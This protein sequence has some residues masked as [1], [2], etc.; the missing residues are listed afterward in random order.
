[1]EYSQKKRAFFF[2]NNANFIL[3]KG[4]DDISE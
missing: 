1:V 2:L 4:R 3:E